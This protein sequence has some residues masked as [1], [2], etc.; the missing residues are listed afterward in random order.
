M[1]P[2]IEKTVNTVSSGNLNYITVISLTLF[3]LI[4][5]GLGF[6]VIREWV[7]WYT[8]TNE[9]ITL[10]ER[11]NTLLEAILEN[12]SDGNIGQMTVKR[13]NTKITPKKEMEHEIVESLSSD[14][15]GN[16]T[17]TINL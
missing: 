9:R 13:A 2:V 10:Q 14:R 4:I 17:I 11:T 8:K 7:C 12:M 5:I 3:G 15:G 1:Y 6:L 16:K